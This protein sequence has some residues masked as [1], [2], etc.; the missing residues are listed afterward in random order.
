MEP[1]ATLGIILPRQIQKTASCTTSAMMAV[2]LMRSAL[3]LT[4]MKRDIFFI[5][6]WIIFAFYLHSIIAGVITSIGAPTKLMC[7]VMWTT[8]T[9]HQHLST[10]LFPDSDELIQNQFLDS[11][12]T[13][14]QS[15]RNKYKITQLFN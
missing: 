6:E 13:Q 14:N 2:L 4:Y 1:S 8:D 15:S 9:A 12:K 5:L 11:T 3:M 7:S 10:A